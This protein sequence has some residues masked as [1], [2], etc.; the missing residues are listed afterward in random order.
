MC[1]LFESA[2]WAGHLGAEP[3]SFWLAA[4]DGAALAVQP[5]RRRIGYV[6]GDNLMR[7]DSIWIF[8][9]IIGSLRESVEFIQMINMISC[10]HA[11]T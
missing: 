3:G 1:R 7:S 10:V 11:G 2:W 5:L 6:N 4:V 9:K 8:T